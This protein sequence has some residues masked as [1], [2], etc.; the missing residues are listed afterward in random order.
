[1]CP[2]RQTSHL[3][4]NMKRVGL[5]VFKIRLIQDTIAK[6]CRTSQLLLWLSLLALGKQ[7]HICSWSNHTVGLRINLIVGDWFVISGIRAW[8]TPTKLSWWSAA[9]MRLLGHNNRNM[10]IHSKLISWRPP[11]TT[12]LHASCAQRT[13]FDHHETQF[14]RQTRFRPWK[15]N[16]H[17]LPQMTIASLFVEEE[18]R[19]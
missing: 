5:I 13:F 8:P 14:G 4:R 9:A 18:R 2:T 12:F 15:V 11:D 3:A 6:I 7:V 10:Q 17:H 1:M 16:H 19:R